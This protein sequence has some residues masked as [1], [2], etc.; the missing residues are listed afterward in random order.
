MTAVG[1]RVLKKSDSLES[2]DLE[3]VIVMNIPESG[4]VNSYWSPSL[5]PP[6]R[7]TSNNITREIKVQFLSVETEDRQLLHKFLSR[8]RAN[9]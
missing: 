5:F 9:S 3:E 4:V 8:I 1:Q 2:D 6:L 7:I